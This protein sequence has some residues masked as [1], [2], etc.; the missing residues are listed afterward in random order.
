[1]E[2]KRS[3]NK[4]S[5]EGTVRQI[6]ESK[7]TLIFH[8]RVGSFYYDSMLSRLCSYVQLSFTPR[9]LLYDV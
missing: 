2:S 9:I 5:E 7:L 8:I 6:F 4:K 1:M 3:S